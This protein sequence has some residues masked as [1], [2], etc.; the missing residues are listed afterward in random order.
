VGS[1]VALAAAHGLLPIAGSSPNVGVVGYLIGGGLGPLAR[2][3]GFSSDYIAGATVVSGAGEV[4]EVSAT[5]NPDLFWAIRGGKYELG[6]VTEIR[7]RLVEL[8]SLYGGFLLFGTDDIERVLRGWSSWTTTAPDEVSTSLALMSFPD[9]EQVPPFLRGR[10]VAM[11]RFGYPGAASEGEA[12]AAPLR[13]LAEAEMD[14][15]GTLAAGDIAQIHNDPTDPGPSWLRGVFLTAFPDDAAS[16]LLETV[17][18]G[19]PFTIA[20]LRH[21]GG[22]LMQETDTEDSSAVGG[23]EVHMSI[24]FGGFNPGRFAE[25][26]AASDRMLDRLEQWIA[27][28]TNINFRGDQVGARHPL[29]AWPDATNERIADVRRKYDPDGVFR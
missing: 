25:L 29:S 4:L 23:R 17:G 8:A 9:M 27:P 11:L 12:L 26:P 14:T 18:E 20:E 7:V 28:F 5:E 6:V 24:G 15:I 22:S 19:S 10:R 21:Y 1:V 2:T 13:A 3:Y 16:I